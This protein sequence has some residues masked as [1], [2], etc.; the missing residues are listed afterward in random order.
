MARDINNTGDAFASQLAGYQQKQEQ[1]KQLLA[2]AKATESFIKSQPDLFGGQ[3]VVDQLLAVDPKESPLQRYAKLASFTKEAMGGAEIKKTQQAALQA[4]AQTKMLAGELEQTKRDDAAFQASFKRFAGDAGGSVDPEVL[5][6]E[7]AKQGGSPSGLQR[8]APVLDAMIRSRAMKAAA[9][10]KPQVELK[11]VTIKNVDKNGNPTEQTVDAITGKPLGAP[12][13]LVTPKYVLTPEEQG[14]AELAKTSGAATAT[15]AQKLL[16]EVGQVAESA[17]SNLRR[18]DQIQSLYDQGEKSGWAQG[19]V[20]DITSAAV[21]A[22]VYPRDKQANKEQLQTLLATDALQKSAEY[23]KGQGAVSDSERKRIDNISANIGKTP[24]AN[25]AAI[26]MSKALNV[27]ALEME[28]IRRQL[29]DAGKNPVEVAENIRRW[30]IDNPLPAFEE[31]STA[32][33]QSGL[34]LPPGWTHSK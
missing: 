3:Q 4:M 13:P 16:D 29:T 28:N 7:Y 26:R 20:N 9:D 22:G 15:S 18:M 10:A 34:R 32:T 19:I 25:L 30:R 24:E 14:Q 8:M 6:T 11:P 21:R 23:F 31:A 33:N 1:N 27:R 5:F 17:Q 2:Q 12:A